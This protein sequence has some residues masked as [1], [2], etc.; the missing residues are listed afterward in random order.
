MNETLMMS[1]KE[2]LKCLVQQSTSSNIYKSGISTFKT[3]NGCRRTGLNWK[4]P[5]LFPIQ[6]IHSMKE[7]SKYKPSLC[8]Y[9]SK[10]DRKLN[11]LIICHKVCIT[12]TR[13]NTTFENIIERLL[14]ILNRTKVCTNYF[15][16]KKFAFKDIHVSQIITHQN[17]ILYIN[18]LSNIYLLFLHRR[19]STHLL[20]SS[21]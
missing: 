14:R 15:L 20:F 21:Q 16:K 3:E 19:P 4:R 18:M 1:K 7:K 6:N 9:G 10:L 17:K 5:I 13:K 2:T 12:F 11:T 8:E